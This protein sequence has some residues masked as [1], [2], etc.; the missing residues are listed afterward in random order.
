MKKPD[1][2]DFWIVFLVCALVIF[3]IIGC[4]EAEE[5]ETHPLPEEDPILEK[6]IELNIVDNELN[7]IDDQI[8]NT[9]EK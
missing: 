3:F 8:K 1:F 6:L 2:E 4:A 7:W 9:E 5:A